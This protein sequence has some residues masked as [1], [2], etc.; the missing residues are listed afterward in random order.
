MIVLTHEVNE[1][2]TGLLIE[3]YPNIV[4][5]FASV[6]PVSTCQNDTDLFAEDNAPLFV[7]FADYKMGK[8]GDPRFQQ[9]FW[10][11][12]SVIYVSLALYCLVSILRRR[13][14]TGQR[15]GL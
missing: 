15:N 9:S 6:V 10:S 13:C 12:D 8:R 14:Y 3:E 1:D 5:N 4:K 11:K 7:D 2:T